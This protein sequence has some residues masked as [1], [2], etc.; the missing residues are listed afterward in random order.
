VKPNGLLGFYERGGY[1]LPYDGGEVHLP[2]LSPVL[3]VGEAEALGSRG[4]GFEECSGVPGQVAVGVMQLAW[5]VQWTGPI[6]YSLNYVGNIY[7]P[8]V[9]MARFR[10]DLAVEL[11]QEALAAQAA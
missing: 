11:V 3:G 5:A 6:H 1:L 10:S 7:L 4:G 9:L 8:D 2:G